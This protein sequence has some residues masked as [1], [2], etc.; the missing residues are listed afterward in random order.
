LSELEADQGDA[1]TIGQAIARGLAVSARAANATC[2]SLPSSPAPGTHRAAIA[3]HNGALTVAAHHAETAV[4]IAPRLA[5][6]ARDRVRAIH[7]EVTFVS[8]ICRR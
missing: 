6:D 8:R 2:S 3:L 5:L 7:G 4:T 1:R